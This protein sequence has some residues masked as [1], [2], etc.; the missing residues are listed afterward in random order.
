MSKKLRIAIFCAN[1]FAVPPSSKMKDIYAPL[2]LTHYITEKLVKKGHNVTLFAS[3]DS[4]SKAKL[5]S[6]NLVSLVRNKEISRFYKPTDNKLLR[7]QGI[8]GNYEYLLIS[9]LYQM[10]VAK[11]FDIIYISLIGIRPLPFAS[12]CQTP[13]VFTLNS[14]L[15]P[16]NRFFFTEY[17]KR[18]PQIHLIG[19]SKSQIKLAPNLFTDIVYNGIDLKNFHLNLKPKDY[20]LVSGRIVP[21][22]GIYEAIKIAQKTKNKLII[23]GKHT[24]DQYWQKKVKPFLGKNIKYQGVLPY[25]KVPKFYENAKA[26]LFPIKWEE[27]FG[28]V[29]TEA[30]AC[31]TPV[32]AFNRAS[33]PEIIKNGKTGFI[34]KNIKE[35]ADA[36][37]KIDQIDRKECRKWVE[38]KFGLEKMVDEYEKVFF[39]IL[40]LKN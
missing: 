36:V 8:I 25:P 15:A 10:A 26:L 12:L 23:I 19:I 3:S 18:C 35:A 22:K 14:P 38:E 16:Y 27:P 17:K 33:V 29:M 39:R 7:T 4:K 6:N 40:K 9:K 32:I 28:L 13:T 21:G 34:V 2:W 31:G 20:L 30:M 5:V 1:E 37:K 11:K 24:E